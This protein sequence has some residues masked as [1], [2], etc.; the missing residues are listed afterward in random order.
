MHSSALEAPSPPEAL[1]KAYK[2]TM[3][4]LRVMLAIADIGGV[5]EVASVLGIA[6]TTVRTH[7]GHVFEKTGT[8][9]QV[10]LV[11]LLAGFSSPLLK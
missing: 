9:R 2:L 1:A 11:K 7:L 4:E 3:T 10:D 5:P 6:A 8:N